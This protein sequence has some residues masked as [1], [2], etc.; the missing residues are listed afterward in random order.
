MTIFSPRFDPG[1]IGDRQVPFGAVCRGLGTARL[2]SETVD[3]V[4]LDG[5]PN[6]D[7]HGVGVSAETFRKARFIFH[8]DWWA[9]YIFGYRKAK[10][11]RAF[12]TSPRA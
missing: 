1:G 3:A 8:G 5:K 7:F 10:F 11:V 2:A 6:A 4:Q 12:S 9:D